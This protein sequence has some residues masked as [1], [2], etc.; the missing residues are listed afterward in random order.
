MKNRN[1]KNSD[2][3]RLPESFDSQSNTE[4]LRKLNAITL[5]GIVYQK[6]LYL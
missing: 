1:K 4:N 6:Y 3:V 2:N 5:R